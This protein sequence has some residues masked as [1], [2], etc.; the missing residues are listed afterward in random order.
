MSGR[1][2][3]MRHLRLK[4]HVMDRVSARVRAGL[5]EEPVWL[6][7]GPLLSLAESFSCL[8]LVILP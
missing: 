8:L 2:T 4:Q 3:G 5:L 6:K 7:V 1:F